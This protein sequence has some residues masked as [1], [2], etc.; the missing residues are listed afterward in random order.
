MVL[1]HFQRPGA[2]EGM[3]VAEWV[4]RKEVGGRVVIGI[5]Q[6]RTA[7]MQI[8]SLALTQEEEA[9]FQVY[10]KYIRPECLRSDC[11]R[12]FISSSGNPVHSVTNDISRLHESYNVKPATSQEVRRAAETES[13]AMFTESQKEDVAHYLGHT[14]AVAKQHYRMWTLHVV[15]A[16]ATLLDS[17]GGSETHLASHPPSMDSQ[18]SGNDFSAFV[19]R[20]PVST[21]GQPPTKKERVDAEFPSD[22]VFYDKWRGCQYAKRREYLL[23]CFSHRRPSARKV[24]RQIE[25]EGW[26][27]N[28]PTAEEILQM[29]KPAPKLTIESDEVILK[30]VSRQKWKGLAIKDF[31]EKGLGVVATRPFSKGD[32][33]CDY[34][35]KVITA[36]KGRAMM[37]DLDEVG[38]LF[39]FK[40]GQRN[41]CIDAQTFPCECHPNA[42]T[43]GRRIKHSSKRA[44]LKPLRC[45][46]KVDGEDTDVI[47]FKALKDIRVDEELKF[48]YGV[49]RKSFR[50]DGLDLDWLDE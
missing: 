11:D 27:A 6:H 37:Q 25:K 28:H 16:T 20:F 44:N 45:V 33:V 5:S 3:T 12:F 32:I 50:G 1:R 14:S 21:D 40:S 35:G 19:A 8:A 22:R 38:H 2:V 49:N 9:W 47:L 41:L 24:A 43:V 10:Y 31:V 34:H 42:D 13:A 15:A 30:S 26:K 4:N 46:L 29:W 7:T 18:P 48:D 23:S 36:D 17:L 39:F